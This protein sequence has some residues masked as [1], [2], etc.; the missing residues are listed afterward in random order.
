ME[1]EKKE[2]KNLPN[3]SLQIPIIRCHNIHA[4]LDES[5]YQAVIGIRSFVVTL[6]SLKSGVLGDP[7]SEAV[8]LA[9]FLQFC[10]HTV[11]DNRNALGI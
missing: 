9:Q 10:K 5:V 11:G 4:M 7:E 3:S 2:K 1:G 8:F 6:N